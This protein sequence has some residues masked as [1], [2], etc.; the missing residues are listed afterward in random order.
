MT[1]FGAF[2]FLTGDVNFT[3]YGGK[4]C[5]RIAARRYLVIE[6]LNWEDSIGSDAAGMPTYNVTLSE[7]D[8]DSTDVRGP[9]RSCGYVLASDGSIIQEYDG[10][11]VCSREHTDLCLV[12]ACHGY[13]ARSQ[14]SDASGNNYRSLIRAAI[15]ASRS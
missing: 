12:E 13:G 14:L 15:A 10:S 5:K 6:L 1:D 9:L 4:W 11:E 2:K 8:L 7:I 3:D